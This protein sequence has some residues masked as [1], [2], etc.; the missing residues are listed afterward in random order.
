MGYLLCGY[1]LIVDEELFLLRV[2]TGGVEF[3]V[4]GYRGQRAYGGY[5]K[6]GQGNERQLAFDDP[7]GTVEY[8]VAVRRKAKAVIKPY[9]GLDTSATQSGRHGGDQGQDTVRV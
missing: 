3:L 7:G 6:N 9:Q 4:G 2:A 8:A 5:F 1:K